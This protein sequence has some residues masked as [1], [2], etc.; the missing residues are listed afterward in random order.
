MDRRS[1][2][3]FARLPLLER[4]ALRHR[5]R[6]V[7]RQGLIERHTRTL[8]ALHAAAGGDPVVAVATA[9]HGP[10]EIAFGSGLRIRLVFSHPPTVRALGR[11]SRWQPTVLD[12]AAYHGVCWGLYFVAG[13]DLVPILAEEVSVVAGPPG[14]LRLTSGPALQPA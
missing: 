14:G 11:R 3:P 4:W 2:D 12:H 9:A 8:A 13:G 5:L 6:R 7:W 1:G 10:A